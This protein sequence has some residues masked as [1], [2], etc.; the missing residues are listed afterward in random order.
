MTESSESL[1]E[2]PE[3]LGGVTE[4]KEG[5]EPGSDEESLDLLGDDVGVEAWGREVSESPSNN[6]SR[7][8]SSRLNS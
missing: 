5:M 2:F 6:L 1:V 7:S 8:L 4:T 3:S